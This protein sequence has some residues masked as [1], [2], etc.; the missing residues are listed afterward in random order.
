MP[1]LNQVIYKSNSPDIKQGALDTVVAMGDFARANYDSISQLNKDIL[2][3]EQE[4][5]KTK[6]DLVAAETHH[7]QEVQ[8]L[9]Q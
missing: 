4:L 7:K 3:K 8:L 1:S 6:Q 9:K 2:D 5:Q